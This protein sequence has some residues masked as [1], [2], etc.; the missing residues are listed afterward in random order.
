MLTIKCH[1]EK[2]IVLMI[3][4]KYI[5]TRNLYIFLAIIWKVFDI[6]D[7]LY[8][9]FFDANFFAIDVEINVNFGLD[10]TLYK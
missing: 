2:I 3:F 1:K 8:V 4:S 5:N 10:W 6:R 7:C 9:Q